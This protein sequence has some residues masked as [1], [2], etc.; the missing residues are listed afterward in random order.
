[1]PTLPRKVL[2]LAAIAAVLCAPSAGLADCGDPLIAVTAPDAALADLVCEAVTVAKTRLAACGLAQTSPIHIS[3]VDRAMHPT[4]GACLATY[5]PGTASLQVTRPDQ[6]SEV[7]VTNDARRALPPDILFTSLVLHELTHALVQQTAGAVEIGP[8]EHEF[9]ANALEMDSLP[10]R[11]R[12]VLLAA[13]PIAPPGKADLVHPMIYALDSRAFAN[14]AWVLFHA[15]GNGC[16]LVQR[17]LTG[18][19]RFPAH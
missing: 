19:F 9:I 12:D 16:D 18:A 13:R 1:M 14:N 11:W 3:A 8:G 2:R 6:L 5:T 7:M 17:I 15:E 10:E 4:F